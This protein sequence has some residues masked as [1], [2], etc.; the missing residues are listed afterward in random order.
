MYGWAAN[1]GTK[2]KYLRDKDSPAYSNTNN[3][4]KVNLISAQ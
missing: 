4:T 2:L 1:G 3:G